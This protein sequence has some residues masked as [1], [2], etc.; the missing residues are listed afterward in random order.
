MPMT[1]TTRLGVE[2]T[3]DPNDK[4]P[5]TNPSHLIEAMGILPLWIDPA[6]ERP[7]REQFNAKYNFGIHEMKGGKIGEDGSYKY[8]GDPILHP[9]AKATLRDETIYFYQYAMVGIVN[10]KTSDTFMT[11]MD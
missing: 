7:M 11:R 1:A 8:P 9:I 10:T 2:I 5:K 4:F 6:D 3:L